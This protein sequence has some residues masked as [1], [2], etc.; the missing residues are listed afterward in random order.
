MKKK[1]TN[2]AIGKKISQARDE[3]GLSQEDLG[4]E[5]GVGQSRIAQFENDLSSVPDSRVKKLAEVLGVSVEWLIEPEDVLA[6]PSSKAIT[7]GER[8]KF[9]IEMINM[10]TAKLA[11]LS[12]IDEQIIKEYINDQRHI[13]VVHCNAIS[14]V[15]G[16]KPSWLAFG[17]LG[18]Q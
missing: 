16:V 18:E 7:I 10:D 14:I 1:K 3:K 12:V 4:R 5:L 9:R 17:E 8:I 13:T 2:K 6:L 15:I 11:F